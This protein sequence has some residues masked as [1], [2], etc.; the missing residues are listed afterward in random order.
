MVRK[1]M[2]VVAG[3]V[4]LAGMTA[5]PARA[6][7]T[8]K[9]DP[10]HAVVIYKI[11]HLGPANAYGRFTDPTG[12]VTLDN[13]DPSK[14]TFTFEVLTDKVDTGNPKR[15][16]HLK[17]PDFFNAKQ[18]PKIDFKSTSVSKKSDNQY[19]LTGDLT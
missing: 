10:V 18:F 8:Y 9:I 11:S 7:D 15:D 16:A 17:S 19:E 14:S 3:L 6:A 4:L 5:Q 12:S 2:A 13:D 1:A